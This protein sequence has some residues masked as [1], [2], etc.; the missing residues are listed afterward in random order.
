V[1]R[2]YPDDP[3]PGEL[4]NLPHQVGLWVGFE[5]LSGN[6]FNEIDPSYDKKRRRGKV[7]FKEITAMQGGQERGVLAST[8]DWVTPEG[9]VLLRQEEEL[10]VYAEPKDCRMMD[11]KF[12]LRP[13][14]RVTFEDE[15]DGILALR[16]G[17]PFMA[18]N[19]G[20][21]SNFTGTEGADQVIGKRSPWV[22]FEGTMDGR[23]RVGVM[24][25]DHPDNYNFPL[26]WKVRSTG[27]I[28]A[29]SFGE[30]D[31]YDDPPFKQLYSAPP[32]GAKDMGLTLKKDE[33]LT[34]R[35]RLLIHPLPMDLNAEW[36]KFAKPAAK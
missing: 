2:G 15:A 18:Q 34:F 32:N 4:L 14:E 10:T 27:S 21:V 36:L 8:A 31:F 23:E 25:M 13:Q 5:K 17:V 19:G 26:R 12:V 16:L 11:V 33:A 28:Y 35:F 1:T 9:K 29:S 20:R 3:Q 30:R 22:E 7:V 6:D 24:L